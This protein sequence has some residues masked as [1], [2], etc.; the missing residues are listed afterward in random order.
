MLG[1]GGCDLMEDIIVAV[2]NIREFLSLIDR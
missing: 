1:N 2:P